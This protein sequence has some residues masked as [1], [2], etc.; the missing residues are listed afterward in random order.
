MRQL[1]INVF[2]APSSNPKTSTVS[3]YRL[4]ALFKEIHRI[5]KYGIVEFLNSIGAIKDGGFL[6]ERVAEKDL[7]LGA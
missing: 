7:L 1:K 4:Q 2:S 6:N 3:A 5:L